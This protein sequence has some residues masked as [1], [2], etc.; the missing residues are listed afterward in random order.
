MPTRSGK[1]LVIRMSSLGDLILL[2]PLLR[3]IRNSFQEKEITLLTKEK[4]AGLF[5]DQKFLDRLILLK[6]G[7]LRELVRLRSELSHEHFDLII[8]AH[9]VIRSNILFHT[10]NA[11]KKLQIRKNEAAKTALIKGKV[12]WYK[13]IVSQ[14]RRYAEIAKRLEITMNTGSA[15]ELPVPDAAAARAE[16]LFEGNSLAGRTVIALAPGAR[17]PT[18]VWP[19]EHF[20][21]LIHEVSARGF[22]PVL[23]GGAEEAASNAEI[24]KQSGSSLLDLTGALSIMESAAVLKRCAALVTNDSAPLHLAEAVGTPVVAFFGPTVREFGY[25]PR[26]ERSIALEV[27]LPCRPCSRNGAR[28]CPYGTK[29]CLVAIRP[30]EALTALLTVLGAGRSLS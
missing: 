22:A 10:L 30:E 11:K 7:N 24:A 3:T 25:F 15:A 14:S 16:R 4:Y 9:H 27:K 12:N 23:I 13:H 28:A 5:S 19:K 18:K 29:E 1:I 26:L 21:M 6:R 8:D 20:T 17:W 2:V